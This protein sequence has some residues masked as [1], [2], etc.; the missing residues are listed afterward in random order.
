[1]ADGRDEGWECL[2]A[3]PPKD[4]TFS[5]F[6]ANQSRRRLIATNPASTTIRALS[7]SGTCVTVKLKLSKK[8]LKPTGLNGGST[9]RAKRRPTALNT[10]PTA[11]MPGITATG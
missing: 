6:A 5:T 4:I 11:A 1:M 3:E 9:L 10:T 8:F 2:V 7:G